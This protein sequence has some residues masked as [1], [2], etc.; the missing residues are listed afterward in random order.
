MPMRWTAKGFIVLTVVLGIYYAAHPA[1]R[2]RWLAALRI[3]KT[4]AAKLRAD[5][6]RRKSE[7][8]RAVEE[9]RWRQPAES[10]EDPEGRRGTGMSREDICAA[11]R[12]R[13]VLLRAKDEKIE[14]SAEK[15]KLLCTDLQLDEAARE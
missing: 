9:A 15:L 13:E 12:E 3:S 10:A 1:D 2:D 8:A 4:S 11:L 6:Q 5:D 14:A 7:Q